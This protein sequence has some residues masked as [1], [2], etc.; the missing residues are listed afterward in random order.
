MNESGETTLKIKHAYAEY[1]TRHAGDLDND[2]NNWA[3][4]IMNLIETR[5]KKKNPVYKRKITKD[6]SDK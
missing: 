2:L 4:N 1:K 5:K 3:K 6:S